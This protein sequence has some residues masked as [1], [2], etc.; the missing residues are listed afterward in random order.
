MV[1]GISAVHTVLRVLARTTGQRMALVARV[2]RDSWTACAVLDE[3]GWGLQP[4]LTLDVATTYCRDLLSR[5]SLVVQHASREEAFAEHPGYRV[6]GIESYVAVPIHRVDGMPFGVLC[7]LDPEPHVHPPDVIETFRLHAQLIAFL[8]EAEERNV[9]S[10]AA[11]SDAAATA[12]LR[13]R[14]IGVLGHDLR[15]PLNAIGVSAALLQRNEERPLALQLLR[16]IGE[17][18]DRITQ[19]VGELLDFTRGRLG[20]GIPIETTPVNVRELLGQV[21]EELQPG[22]APPIIEVDAPTEEIADWDPSRM[23]QSFSNLVA[24]AVQHGPGRVNISLRSSADEVVFETHNGGEPIP[25]ELLPHL[26]DPFR[27][28]LVDEPGS[29]SS[30]L[31]LGLYIAREIVHAHGGRIEVCSDHERGTTFSVRMPRRARSS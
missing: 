29:S 2:T 26:F 9:A 19:M 10:A 17:S 15:N 4:G 24:N 13:E 6:H 11:L 30:G 14:F 27:R 12:E 8:I 28:G 21:I 20:G 25:P 16:R 5:P 7:A 1:N 23:A 3:A 18:T 22:E 31:G